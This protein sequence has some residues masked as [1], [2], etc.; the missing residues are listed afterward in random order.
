MKR[1]W[2]PWRIEYI[3]D[4]KPKACFLCLKNSRGY[5]KRH[6]VL[7]ESRHT[8]TVL[9]RFPYITGH[10]M[11]ITKRHVA[12]MDGLTAEEHDDFFQQV[13]L[14]A[15]RLKQALRPDG[16][17]IGANLGKGAGAGAEAHLHFHIVP[18]WKGDHNFMPIIGETMSL[19]E[20]LDQTY[21][22]ML[23]FFEEPQPDQRSSTRRSKA[24]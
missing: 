1:I 10:L 22:R 17:N 2:S 18:R 9:N 23:P 16:L 12:D 6:H 5:R 3:L 24:R 7:S 21:N 11:V 4:K 19:P 8:Y 13:R 15:R 20:A 14:A